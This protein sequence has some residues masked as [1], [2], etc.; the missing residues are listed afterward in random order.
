MVVEQIDSEGKV[1]FL[2]HDQQAS[3][4]ML[5][6]TTGTI[7]G[8]MSY[9]AYGNA[10]GSTG[11]A[12]TPLGYDGQYTNS[13]TGLIYLRARVYDPATAQFLSSDLL[14]AITGEPYA[15]AGDNPVNFSDPTGLLFGT[16]LPSWEE[17]GEGIAGWGDTLTLGATNWVREELGNNNINTCSGAYEAGGYAGLATAV[18]IPGEG[19]LA[20]AD[21]AGMGATDLSEQLALEEAQAGAGRRIMEGRINDPQY[22]EDAWAK[23]EHVHRSLDG[24]KTTVHYWEYIETGLRAGFKIK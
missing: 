19:E 22:P 4:R 9:D 15:Y 17:V 10:A 8:T 12:T 1:L 24:S 11:T 20:A 18:L 16:S 14:K 3:T 2:H 23:M 13:D 7:Q 6:D 21:V 5:T